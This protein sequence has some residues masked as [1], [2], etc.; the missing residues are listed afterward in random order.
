MAQ[1]DSDDARLEIVGTGKGTFHV[2][3][4]SLMPGDNVQGFRR[5][6]VAALKSLRSGVYRFPGGNYVSGFEWTDAIGDPDQRPPALGLRLDRGAA[7]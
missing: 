2:G 5:E 7:K 6:V 3:A 1:A 4:V